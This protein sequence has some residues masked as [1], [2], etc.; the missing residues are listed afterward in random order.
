MNL[1]RYTFNNPIRFIDPYGLLIIDTTKGRAER[2]ARESQVGSEIWNKLANDPNVLVIIEDGK[3]GGGYGHTLPMNSTT[4]NVVINPNQTS[5][6]YSSTLVHELQHVVDLMVSPNA[7]YEDYLEP[8]AQN[9][10]ALISVELGR[11]FQ[12]DS[13]PK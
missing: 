6:T 5:N 9:I 11:Q 8:R 10:E 1:Y 12:G 3:P 4:Y 13:C 7:S 2:S